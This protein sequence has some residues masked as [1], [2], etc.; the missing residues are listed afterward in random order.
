MSDT[1]TTITDFDSIEP[2]EY[3]DTRGTNIG[4]LIRAEVAKIEAPF[5]VYGTP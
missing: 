3:I 1:T 2:R 5:V 4:T